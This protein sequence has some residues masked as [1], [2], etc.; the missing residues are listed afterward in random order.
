MS[1]GR[2]VRF[3]QLNSDRPDVPDPSQLRNQFLQLF[4]AGRTGVCFLRGN[5]DR[6]GHLA[7]ANP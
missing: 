2:R 3:D 5:A 1:A 7:S 4:R 6:G